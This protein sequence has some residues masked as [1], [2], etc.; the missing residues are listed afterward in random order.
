MAQLAD[1]G[2]PGRRQHAERPS[3]DTRRD[4]GT[5]QGGSQEPPLDLRVP[6]VH[7]D[8]EFGGVTA[9]QHRHD[10]AS[11][12]NLAGRV[13]AGS[14]APALAGRHGTHA[15]CSAHTLTITAARSQRSGRSGTASRWVKKRLYLAAVAERGDGHFLDQIGDGH[16]F[17]GA[18]R[19]AHAAAA[20]R[21]AASAGIPGNKTA[22]WDQQQL[23]SV[24]ADRGE[25]GA[26]AGH[27]PPVRR[28]PQE[29]GR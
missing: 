20:E 16:R 25:A 1:P 9:A 6:G 26:Q 19:A 17:G 2:Q 18:V 13:L 29:P 21:A 3:G 14:R 8:A 7:V 22:R 23:D 10:A 12:L 28:L 15:C 24:L 11:Q 27:R 4:P 5:E